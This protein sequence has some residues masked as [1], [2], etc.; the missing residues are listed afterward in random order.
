MG[1]TGNRRILVIGSQC[2]RLPFLSFLPQAAVDLHAVMTDLEVGGCTDAAPRGLLIDPTVAEARAAIKEAFRAAAAE[3][4]TLLLALIGHGTYAGRDFYLLPHNGV[5]PPDSDTGVQLVQLVKEQHRLH[6]V[7]GLVVLIDTCFSGVGALAAATSWVS[8]LEGALRF[9]MLTAAADRPAYDGCFTRRLVAC[10]REGLDGIPGEYLR[11]E[12]VKRVIEGLC[13]HQKPQHPTYNADEG[14]YLA[15]NVIHARRFVGP[16]WAG[17]ATAETI[18]RLTAWLQPTPVLHEVVARSQEGRYV[19]V[20][21]LAGS[22]KSALA[23]A[24]ARPEVTEGTVPS[25]FVQAVAFLTS[26]TLTPEVASTLSDQLARS[27]PGFAATRDRFQ[28]ALTDDEKRQLDSLQRDVLGPL[29]WLG[30]GEVIRVVIDGLD[31]LATASSAAVH[32]ALDALVTDPGLSRV[33]LVVTSRPDTPRPAGASEVRLDVAPD[34][35]IRSYLARRKVPES[36]HGAIAVRAGGNWLIASLLADQALKAPG[37][38]PE[39]LPSDLAGLYAQNLRG[40]SV[41]DRALARRVP[42]G[43]WCAGRRRGRS[44]PPPEAALRRQRAARRSRSPPSGARPA[45]RPAG[46][47]GPCPPRHRQ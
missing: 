21:G 8:E 19:A 12:H 34:A 37:I 3:E 31:Q 22:G 46:S 14:L 6:P 17:T 1:I 42:A 33:R 20:A 23:A 15:K 43:A 9:E 24:L 27:L 45:G 38:A 13:P 10:L 4:A 18:Q 39:S 36:L 29:R 11:S 26:G 35:D 5:E 32:A 40:R 30:G 16:S 28:Q 47:R 44:H 2:A 25:D 41:G 7:D